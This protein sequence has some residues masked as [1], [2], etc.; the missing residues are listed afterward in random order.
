MVILPTVY[1]F[2]QPPVIL[3]VAVYQ[4]VQNE[5][6]KYPRFRP[7]ADLELEILH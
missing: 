7:R 6:G 2:S 1:R 4:L 5:L 3:P